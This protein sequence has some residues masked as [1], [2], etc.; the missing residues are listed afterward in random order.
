MWHRKDLRAQLE[1]EPTKEELREKIE[2]LTKRELPGLSSQDVDACFASGE[3]VRLDVP[4]C[5]KADHE[6]HIDVSALRFIKYLEEFQ[7]ELIDITTNPRPRQKKSRP[8]PKRK[9]KVETDSKQTENKPNAAKRP[10]R[11]ASDDSYVD[12]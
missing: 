2:L 11:A 7:L 5:Y 8:K 6:Q 4:R 3:L 9:P 12:D 10:R 1:R